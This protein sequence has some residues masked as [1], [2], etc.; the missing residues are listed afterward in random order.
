MVCLYME[1]HALNWGL[2]MGEWSSEGQGQP[3]EQLCHP[4]ELEDKM[5][6]RR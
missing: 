1:I 6:S 3:E 4:K 5:G 2:G